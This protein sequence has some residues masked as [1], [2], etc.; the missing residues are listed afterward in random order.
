[1]YQTVGHSGLASIATA[2]ELPLFTHTIS[3]QPLNLESHYGSRE[4]TH[5]AVKGKAKGTTGDE[6]EDLM[7]LLS[8]VKVS[9]FRRRL[10]EP[11]EAREWRTLV[12]TAHAQTDGELGCTAQ[13]AMPEV[14]GVACGAILSNYQRVRVEHVQVVASPPGPRDPW[15]AWSRA[16]ECLLTR[17]SRARLAGVPA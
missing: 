13:A 5:A 7:A 12:V 14:T 4:G 3:G 16:R 11:C 1:M 2:L 9:Q 10:P 15:R 8:K 6:T 17:L